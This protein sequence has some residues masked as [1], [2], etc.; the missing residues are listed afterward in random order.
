MPELTPVMEPR[1]SEVTIWRPADGPATI[2]T[3]SGARYMVDGRRW[4][5][6]GS[7]ARAVVCGAVDHPDGHVRVPHVAVGL[8]MEIVR[9]A[10]AE[11]ERPW[12]RPA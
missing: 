9:G 1:T 11:E 5:R 12:H 4:I 2:R 10:G 3:A 6:G 8:R 7:L